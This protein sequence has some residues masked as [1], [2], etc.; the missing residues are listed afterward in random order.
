[1][2]NGGNSYLF[3]KR[4]LYRRHPSSVCSSWM[5]Q[6]SAVNVWTSLI[7]ACCLANMP[8]YIGDA[9]SLA[10]CLVFHSV[11]VVLDAV[12]EVHLIPF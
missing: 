2:A 11:I 10:C 12:A 7:K 8:V 6:S 3:L 4:P 9:M 1:M 5:L